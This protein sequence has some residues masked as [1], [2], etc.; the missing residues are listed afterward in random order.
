MK[1]K[2][3]FLKLSLRRIK[4]SLFTLW[5]VWQLPLGGIDGT[6]VICTDGSPR[7]SLPL[8]P[9]SNNATIKKFTDAGYLVRKPHLSDFGSGKFW[10]VRDVGVCFDLAAFPFNEG[11]TCKIV[12]IGEETTTKKIFEVVCDEGAE[13]STFHSKGVVL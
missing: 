10:A 9:P 8:D 11:S 4:W 12:G 6:A 2:L 3:A 13:E 7:I 1:L 5:K